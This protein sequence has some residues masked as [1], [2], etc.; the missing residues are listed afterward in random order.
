[1][2][3]LGSPTSTREVPPSVYTDGT[4]RTPTG[5]DT[6]GDPIR[7]SGDKVERGTRHIRPR[8]PHGLVVRRPPRYAP[9]DGDGVPRPTVEVAA[10][11]WSTP[12]TT[13][14]SDP[15][16]FPV[17]RGGSPEIPPSSPHVSF[18][19]HRFYVFRT[20][21]TLQSPGLIVSRPPHPSREQRGD[22]RTFHPSPSLSR[23][24]LDPTHKKYGPSSPTTLYPLLSS[25]SGAKGG[26]ED[27][28]GG[29]G[30]GSE[31]RTSRP[32]V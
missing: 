21:S 31:D 23:C 2:V 16:D 19:L 9:G 8:C 12:V 29:P 3:L 13:R 32:R 5:V 30:D 20:P 7:E 24:S 27:D 6:P 17:D 10:T 15:H 25:P 18:S 4:L 22:P 14:W 28:D 26:R 11:V 1:M